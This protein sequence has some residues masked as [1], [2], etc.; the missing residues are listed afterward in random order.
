MTRAVNK[1]L[2]WAC[3]AFG[4]ALVIT[5][6][7]RAATVTAESNSSLPTILFVALTVLFLIGA[8]RLAPGL[9]RFGLGRAFDPVRHVMLALL[10]VALVKLSGAYLE[11]LIGQLLGGDRDLSRFSGQIDDIGGLL[12]LLAFSWGFA[13]FGEE[14]AFRALLMGGIWHALGGTRRAALIALIVQSLVFGAVHLYQGP[15]GLVGAGISGLVF[16]GLVIAAR[17]SLWPAILAHGISNSISLILL[18]QSG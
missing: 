2:L 5:G 1:Q 15:V 17:G 8:P 16:G 12:S 6:L 9:D 4:G 11:P 13:A 7:W 14:L 18:Y 10:G 3:A